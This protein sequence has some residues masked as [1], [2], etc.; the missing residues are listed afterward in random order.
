MIVDNGNWIAEGERSPDKQLKTVD[1]MYALVEKYG[2]LP[3]FKNSIKGFSVEEYSNPD[4]WWTDSEDDAWYWR[5]LAARDKRVMYGKLFGKKAGFISK[6]WLPL[7][8]AYRRKGYDFDAR[9]EDGLASLKQKRVM[10]VIEEKGIVPSY[11]LKELAGFQKG[12]ET[13]FE[14]VLTALQ[15]LTYISVCDFSK[16]L[17]KKGEPYGWSIANYST[18]ETCMGEALVRA[19]YDTP[20][21]ELEE[22]LIGNILRHFP[23]ADRKTALAVISPK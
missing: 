20:R 21:E 1:E 23:H 6:K 15:M 12:G 11:L 9:F 22:K 17:N 4:A 8:A 3:L 10:D 7:L 14:T 13:G 2:F 5:E 18:A 16:K 19:A